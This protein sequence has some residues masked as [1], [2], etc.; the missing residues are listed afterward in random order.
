MYVAALRIELRI[1]NVR[2]LKEK[3]Q[4]MRALKAMLT[5][6]FPV[7]VA[8]VGFQEAWQRTTIGIAAVA[9]QAGHLDRLLHT[10]EEAIR[11]RDDVEIL[12]VGVSHLEDPV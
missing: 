2:S 12:E 4:V 8:E 10:V 5:E 9:P 3:R 7:S 11:H 6:R 1:P